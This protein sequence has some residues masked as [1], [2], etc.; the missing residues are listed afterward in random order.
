M[1]LRDNPQCVGHEI[2]GALMG[3]LPR[4]RGAFSL[5]I[6]D[7][8]R[9]VGVRDPNGF[10]PL[11]LGRLDNG[12]VLASESPALDVLGAHLVRELELP[13]YDVDAIRSDLPLFP[14]QTSG[15]ARPITPGC[16]GIPSRVRWEHRMCRWP[17]VPFLPTG[18][19][20]G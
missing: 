7:A 6:T 5:V 14:A 20:V 11:C 15:A 13:A 2:E 17:W 8:H 18:R 16:R 4:L 12:W 9:I 3:V 1:H 19:A 10:R